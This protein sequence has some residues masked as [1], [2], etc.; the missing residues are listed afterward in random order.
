LT[1]EGLYGR[2][3]H[4]RFALE[5]AK[6]GGPAVNGIRTFWERILKKCENAIENTGPLTQGRIPSPFQEKKKASRFCYED[7]KNGGG[8]RERGKAKKKKGGLP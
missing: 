2:D 3:R 8:K 5:G 4:G 7:Q 6:R 1:E